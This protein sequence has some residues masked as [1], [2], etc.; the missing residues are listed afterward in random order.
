M[1][2]IISN[3]EAMEKVVLVALMFIGVVIGFVLNEVV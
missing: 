3:M 1:Y 2:E